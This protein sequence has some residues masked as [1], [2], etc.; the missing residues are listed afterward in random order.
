MVN[1]IFP[2]VGIVVVGVKAIMTDSAV[3]ATTVEATVICRPVTAAHCTA[4]AR[5]AKV[6]NAK[7]SAFMSKQL[8]LLERS[9]RIP[10]TRAKPDNLMLLSATNF[11]P[12]AVLALQLRS[13][14]V[15]SGAVHAVARRNCTA[16]VQL[17]RAP[18]KCVPLHTGAVQ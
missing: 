1:V 14:T 3:D 11:G 6:A 13:V 10:C 18:K 7:M 17:L 9:F 5:R 12:A 4:G 16:A 15:C 8:I 2:P